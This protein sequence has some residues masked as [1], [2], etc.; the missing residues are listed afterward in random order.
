MEFRSKRAFTLIELLVVIAIIAVLMGILMPAL[1]RVREQARMVSC[2][3]NHKQWTLALTT[4]ASE[5]DGVL[6]DPFHN[7]GYWFV[8]YLPNKI[9]DWKINKTWLCPS[10]KQFKI[11]E[12][13]NVNPTPGIFTTWGIF[14][15]DSGPGTGDNGVNGSYAINGYLLK[16]QGSTYEGGVA[17]SDGWSNFNTMRNAS[18][19]PLMIEALRFDLWPLPTQAPAQQEEAAWSGNNM[20]RTCINRHKGFVCSSFADGSARKVGLKELWT[21]KWSQVFNTSGPF[22]MAGGVSGDDWPEWLRRYPD[23]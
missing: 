21:L 16:I 5:N 13:G 19:I 18:E 20:G 12:Q 3:A 23:F 4:L 22:T 8:N 17:A 14:H 6:L 9:K 2:T 10:T 11:D 7:T 1:R 15:N